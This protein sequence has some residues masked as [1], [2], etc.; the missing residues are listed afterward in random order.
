MEEK[1]MALQGRTLKQRSRENRKIGGILIA[2]IVITF[3]LIL[4]LMVF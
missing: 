4:V 1:M 3:A 2:A